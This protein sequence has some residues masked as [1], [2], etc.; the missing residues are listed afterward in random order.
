MHGLTRVVL[1]VEMYG[2]WGKE[3][4]V[5]I[6]R[7]ASHLDIHQSTHKSSVVA[8]IYLAIEYC[9]DPVHYQSHPFYV[10]VWCLV[11]CS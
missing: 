9:P 10:C 4:H 11:F 5:T 3:A 2:N 1:T 7:V 8:E 6:S